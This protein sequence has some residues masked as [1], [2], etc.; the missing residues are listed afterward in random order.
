MIGNWRLVE[1]TSLI[2]STHFPWERRSLALCSEPRISWWKEHNPRGLPYKTNHLNI[3][4]LKFV[5]ELSK[6]TEFG[7][8]NRGEIGRVREKDGPA[9]PD[10]LVEVNLAMCGLS[11]E[12]GSCNA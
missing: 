12:V 11:I 8:A 1:A 2:S 7:R 10:E 5:L 6:S 3:P 4:L 9:I